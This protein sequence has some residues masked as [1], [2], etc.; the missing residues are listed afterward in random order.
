MQQNHF[1]RD[2]LARMRVA[3][4]LL[5]VGTAQNEHR[6]VSSQPNFRVFRIKE[7]GRATFVKLKLSSSFQVQ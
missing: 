2:K 5:A 7:K 1:P 3:T 4:T 6:A